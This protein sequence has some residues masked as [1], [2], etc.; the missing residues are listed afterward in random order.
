MADALPQR[1][2]MLDDLAA[3]ARSVPAAALTR[4]PE[5]AAFVFRGCGSA[6]ERMGAAFGV[7]MPRDACRFAADAGRTAF[8]L[9][10]DEWLL[11]A[12]NE[13]PE[14]FF[15]AAQRELGAL[16][17]SLVDVSHRS[18]RI[19]ITGSHSAYVLNHGCPLDLSLKAFPVGMCT[20]TIFGKATIMLW[21]PEESAFRLDVWRSF[22]PYVW[23]LLDEAR[24]ELA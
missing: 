16:A 15:A 5:T 8:W 21:R 20:R 12:G 6:V 19:A 23:Q 24:S 4:L 11:D 2:G 9:G 3:T 14:T 17:H 18:M 13:A 1:H 7:A 22:A 10:P